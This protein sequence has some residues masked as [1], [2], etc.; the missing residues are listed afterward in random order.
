MRNNSKLCVSVQVL[1]FLFIV[2]R[3]SD[4]MSISLAM[5]SIGQKT[6]KSINKRSEPISQLNIDLHLPRHPIRCRNYTLLAGSGARSVWHGCASRDCVRCPCCGCQPFSPTCGLF[7]HAV[8]VLPPRRRPR[9]PRGRSVARRR[10]R[11]ARRADPNPLDSRRREGMLV[12]AASARADDALGR[13]QLAHSG[14]CWVEWAQPDLIG[15][16]ID[17]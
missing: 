16:D 8:P 3:P 6:L 1:A 7:P 17:T 15:I 5:V 11:P 13:P 2:H 10:P 12:S 4:P 14:R 9:Y